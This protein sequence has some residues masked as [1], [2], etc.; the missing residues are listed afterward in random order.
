METGYNPVI[1][2][3]RHQR[4]NWRL[5]SMLG[6]AVLLI[7][8]VF[9]LAATSRG[10]FKGGGENKVPIYVSS[11]SKINQQ[12]TLNGGFSPIAKAIMPAV[13]VVNIEGRRQQQQSPFFFD[14]F[15]DLFNNPDQDDE[16]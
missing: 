1:N 2:V 10:W 4:F 16:G 12:V 15:G 6:A 14:P 3:G 11:D 9:G 13:V 5:M 7:G 8:A